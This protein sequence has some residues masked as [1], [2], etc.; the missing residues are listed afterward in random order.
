M[1]DRENVI[2]FTR[3][4]MDSI[5]D[6]LQLK[7]SDKTP[8][9]VWFQRENEWQYET[10]FWRV[11]IVPIKESEVWFHGKGDRFLY[12]V[13]INKDIKTRER[14]E[15]RGMFENLEMAKEMSEGFLR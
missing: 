1:T 8:V 7:P 2:E 10:G 5:R 6:F 12:Q 13:Y 11:R 4:V 3:G 15:L 9:G 14:Y